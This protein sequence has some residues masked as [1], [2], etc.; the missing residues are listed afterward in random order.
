MRK[1][2]RWLRVTI[3]SFIGNRMVGKSDGPIFCG[4][5]TVLSKRVI[6]GKNVNF[7]GMKINGRG[8]VFIGDNFHSGSEC[9]ILTEN[10][11]YEGVMIPYD[12]TFVVKDVYIG[13]NVWLGNRVIILPGVRIEEGAIIQAGSVVVSDIPNCAIAG[14]HPAKVFSSRNKAHYFELKSQGMVN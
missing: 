5:W 10:H 11:N 9:Q 12:N 7:N 1:L 3:F 13:E 6:V 14:G 2:V 4:G 8:F